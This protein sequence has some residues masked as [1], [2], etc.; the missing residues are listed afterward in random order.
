MLFRSE[1]LVQVRALYKQSAIDLLLAKVVVAK[2]LLL[3]N[4]EFVGSVRT[5]LTALIE[6]IELDLIDTT[7]DTLVELKVYADALGN[8]MNAFNAAI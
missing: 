2:A 7:N 4:T 6:T 5:T 1:N 8:A 3:N